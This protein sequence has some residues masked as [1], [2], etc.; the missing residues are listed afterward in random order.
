MHNTH[1]PPRYRA[2]LLRCWQERGHHRSAWRCSL[3]D[4]HTGERRSF[5]SLEAMLAFLQHHS[6]AED[7]GQASSG[8]DEHVD[9]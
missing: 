6:I 8:N 5:A 3:Q 2:Y 9:I 4:P 1:E 7:E